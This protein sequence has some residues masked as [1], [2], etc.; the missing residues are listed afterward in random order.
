M[1]AL[2]SASARRRSDDGPCRDVSTGGM[3]A[4]A[5]GATGGELWGGLIVGKKRARIPTGLYLYP[6]HLGS[7]TDRGAEAA[8]G[9]VA[10]GV[11]S[12]WRSVS[13]AR[14]VYPVTVIHLGGFLVRKI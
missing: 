2:S 1:M 6:P 9:T 13:E 7:T 3:A 5:A 10:C 12:R 4:E 14:A 8:R 11:R